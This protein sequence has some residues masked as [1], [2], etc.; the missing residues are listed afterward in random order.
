MDGDELM[1]Y[2]VLDYSEKPYK[3]AYKDLSFLGYDRTLCE[4]CGRNIPALHYASGPHRLILEG[5]R[6]YP[7]L[8]GFHGAGQQMFILS[9]KAL[10]IFEQHHISGFG[11]KEQIQV[12]IQHDGELIEPNDTILDYWFVQI[13]GHIEL[14]FSSM[15]LKKKRKCE[16]CGQFDWNHQR[17]YPL[18]LDT[19][20]WNGSDICRI[21]SIPG[22]IVCTDTVV[23][24]VK[25]HSLS[26]FDFIVL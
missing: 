17:F 12:L 18:I 24:L 7:D 6:K 9:T 1:F 14:K 23:G 16:C 4:R 15:R 25:E 19:C 26:G 20:T 21:T 11:E 22:Y 8:L 3:Y 2:R 13:T 5:G 10:S